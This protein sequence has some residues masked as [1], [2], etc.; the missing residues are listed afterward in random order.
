MVFDTNRAPCKITNLQ[1][2]FEKTKFYA[3][4][5]QADNPTSNDLRMFSLM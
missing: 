1:L 4:W 2:Y 5:T 3:S